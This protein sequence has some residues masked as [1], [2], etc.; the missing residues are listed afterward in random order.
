MISIPAT[1]LHRMFEQVT[2]HMDDPDN[3][4]PAISS[5]RLESRDAWLYA[6][7]TDR[8][9]FA[10][11]RREIVP[12]G[13]R[14]GNVPGHLVPAITAWLKVGATNSDTV[15]LSLPVDDRPA[16]ITFTAP[17][18]GKLTIEYDADD[19]KDFPDWRPILRPA[20]TATPGVIPVTGFNTTFLARWQHAAD[21]LA[22]WQEA[23]G[24]PIV[25]L[26]ELGYFA[27]LHCPIRYDRDKTTREGLAE[28]WI[29]ATA[30]TTTV[31]GLTYDL[32]KTWADRHGD[33]W[34]YSGKDCPDGMPLMVIDGIED[35]PHPLD[36]LISQYGPLYAAA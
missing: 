12:D 18:R 16:P 3:Y 30:R 31:D 26:D 28:E 23:P 13:N 17:G 22:V 5:I 1:D 35:D 7:A 14:T 20:L 21:K 32:D 15:S 6:A 11:A 29:T 33:P 2:P 9:T 4:A 10:I 19:Y 8:Y 36:R 25:L 27:G 34:T 24:K